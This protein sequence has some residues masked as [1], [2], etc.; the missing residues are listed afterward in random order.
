MKL[1][2]Y[3]FHPILIVIIFWIIPCYISLS[4]HALNYSWSKNLK[5]LIFLFTL[6]IIFGLI[7][8]SILNLKLPHFK[9]NLNEIYLK[10]KVLMSIYI[11][12]FIFMLSLIS[13]KI[14]MFDSSARMEL[15]DK[16]GPIWSLFISITFAL[17]FIFFYN[18][19]ESF[20]S[21]LIFLAS[22][23]VFGW[24]GLILTNIA[25][26]VIGFSF[27]KK[28]KISF[29]HV[30][31]ALLVISFLFILINATRGGKSLS[32]VDTEFIKNYFVL[33]I[34]PNFLNLDNLIQAVD[35]SDN[36]FP[37][38][39][40][41]GFFFLP[42]F[43]KSVYFDM[44]PKDTVVYD[45]FNV[46]T[47]LAPSYIGGGIFELVL[48]GFTIT[49]AYTTLYRNIILYKNN[50]ILTIFLFGILLNTFIFLHNSYF[51]LSTSP[52]I[53]LL[54]LYVLSKIRIIR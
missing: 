7:F 5:S 25:F 17:S 26:A 14:P 35:S 41:F 10:K 42:L 51:L 22:L 3:L 46:W 30:F 45:S 34:F 37:F 9:R 54:L 44:F 23:C 50:C 31:T 39:F 49:F 1:K 27:I 43:G 36:Y 8:A 13:F 12:L 52:F 28:A 32:D 48:M 6:A 24:K 47:G 21:Y 15:R 4:D 29:S 20:I 19:N 53:S 18:K 11:V 38:I 40:S 33:Y 16:S 2:K